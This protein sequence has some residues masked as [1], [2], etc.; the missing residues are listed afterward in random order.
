MA[1]TTSHQAKSGSKAHFELFFFSFFIKRINC[2]NCTADNM[3][4]T[5]YDS[6]MKN[7]P[8]NKTG[9][10]SSELEK[11]I[12]KTTNQK[13]KKR[14]PIIPDIFLLYF[15]LSILFVVLPLMKN[16]SNSHIINCIDIIA[17]IILFCIGI[18][19]LIDKVRK[20]KSTNNNK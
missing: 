2:R 16:S 20:I 15:F 4:T 9:E 6:R 14:Y 3:A 11:S 10:K 12:K 13:G 5:I 7:F 17:M 8:Q 1:T 18:V 19:V